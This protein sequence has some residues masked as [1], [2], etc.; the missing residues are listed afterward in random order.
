ML[1]GRERDREYWLGLNCMTLDMPAI[2][3]NVCGNL[4]VMFC[5]DSAKM[6]IAKKFVDT[7]YNIA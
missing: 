6:C 4:E 3:E 2:V 1:G 5:I 7:L